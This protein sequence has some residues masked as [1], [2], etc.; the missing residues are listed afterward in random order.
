[1]TPFSEHIPIVK[2]HITVYS[3]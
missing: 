3:S 1:M 2:R